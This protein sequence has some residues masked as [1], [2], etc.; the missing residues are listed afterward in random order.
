MLRPPCSSSAHRFTSEQCSYDFQTST[1]RDSK[2]EAPL[3]WQASSSCADIPTTS[4]QDH[5]S[6]C[7]P[8]EHLLRHSN[9]E[10]PL[11]PCAV[12]QLEGMPHD[13]WEGSKAVRWTRALQ[14]GRAKTMLLGLGILVLLLMDWPET[15]EARRPRRTVRNN[16]PMMK[17]RDLNVS[18]PAAKA[19]AQIAVGRPRGTASDRA[20]RAMH[21]KYVKDVQVMLFPTLPL[22]VRP[23]YVF[24]CLPSLLDP[25]FSPCLP[26]LLS[27]WD[28]GEEAQSRC[29]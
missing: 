14:E 9:S 11:D 16:D 10:C 12:E 5:S 18:T 27:W 26:P 13:H 15:A 21:E 20:W 28:G 6:L 19:L 3:P 29:L 4:G 22:I 25:P 17:L 2:N 24:L 8:G 1:S 7:S 23:I